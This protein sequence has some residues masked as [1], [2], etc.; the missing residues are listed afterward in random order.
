MEGALG[1]LRETLSELPDAVERLEAAS[2]VAETPDSFGLW[3][4][5]AARSQ[6]A[7]SQTMT[8]QFELIASDVQVRLYCPPPPQ[9]SFSITDP[10]HVR[11]T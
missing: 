10:R 8:V 6:D 11:R 2:N 1:S 7:L 4:D 9:L 5:E 3:V